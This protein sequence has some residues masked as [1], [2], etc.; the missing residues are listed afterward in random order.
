MVVLVDKGCLC[1]TPYVALVW[2]VDAREMGQAPSDS[3]AALIGARRIIIVT[4]LGAWSVAIF[5]YSKAVG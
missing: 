5:A 4:A 2:E 1:C 3:T